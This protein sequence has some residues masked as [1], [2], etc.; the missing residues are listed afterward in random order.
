MQPLHFR[1]PA[2]PAHLPLCVIPMSLLS[3][4]D[5]LPPRHFSSQKL[6]CLLVAKGSERSGSF[7]VLSEQPLCFLNQASFEHL[8]C[9]TVDALV[10]SL[11]I[12]FKSQT[13]NTKSLQRLPSLLPEVCHLLTRC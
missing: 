3:H 2:K 13:Q 7:A 1:L 8:L 10:Q 11:T 6:P 4:H 12:G 9:A 5:G